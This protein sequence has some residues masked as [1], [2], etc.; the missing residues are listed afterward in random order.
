MS[1]Y[2]LIDL[3]EQYIKAFDS[4]DLQGVAEMLCDDF[5]LEDP[6]VIRVEGKENSLVKIAEIFNNCDQLSFT[7]QNIFRDESNTIIE[8]H[9]KLDD[10]LLKGTDI[11]VWSGD[12]MKELR[13]YLDLPQ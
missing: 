13:A 8:F 6:A 9:L 4:K 1:Q 12:K 3:T 2:N 7:A 10:L 11:I 5:V